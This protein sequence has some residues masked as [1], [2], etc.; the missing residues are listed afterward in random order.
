VSQVVGLNFIKRGMPVVRVGRKIIKVRR[1][2][3]LDWIASHVVPEIE[4]KHRSGF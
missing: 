2:D 4:N 3:L 1:Q